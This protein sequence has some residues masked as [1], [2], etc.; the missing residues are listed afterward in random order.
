MAII[1]IDRLEAGMTLKSDVCDRSGRLL[2]PAGSEL[3]D[4]QLKIL[5]TWGVAEADILCSPDE[6]Q[7]DLPGESCTVDPL[8]RAEAEQ[9]VALLFCHN[10]PQHPMIQEL[11]RICLER[12][13]A[14]VR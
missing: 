9:A 1:P 14:D 6:A 13:L 2:L 3:A 5:R 7:A 10:D 8:I 12:R 4:K 11:M